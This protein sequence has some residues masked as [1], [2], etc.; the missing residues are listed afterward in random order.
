MKP[1]APIIDRM[2][3]IARDELPFP[4]TC[5]VRLWDDGTFD[6]YIYH[7]SP[8]DEGQAIRYERTTGE[9]IW[10]R[11]ESPGWK[12]TQFSDGE[13]L[14]EPTADEREIRVITTVEPPY[15]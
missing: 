15:R 8:S 3:D 11:T 2:R 13:T 12:T 5:R 10:E 9:I 7:S 6:A 14:Y 4:Q 1:L